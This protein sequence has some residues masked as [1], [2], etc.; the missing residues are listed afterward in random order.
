M[1]R[2]ELSFFDQRRGISTISER[3]GGQICCPPLRVRDGV[4]CVPRLV[5]WAVSVMMVVV[6]VVVECGHL[7][8]LRCAW[9][10]SSSFVL[11]CPVLSY[12][13][14][15]L[16][17]RVSRCEMSRPYP[18]LVKSRRPPVQ[19]SVLCFVVDRMAN[20][21][22]KVVDG[23]VGRRCTGGAKS[24]GQRV[25][26]RTRSVSAASSRQSCNQEA[27]KTRS[28]EAETVCSL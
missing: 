20:T 2:P 16:G 9:T 13:P 7:C 19:E 24:R 11:S 4:C 6:V 23:S 17:T 1:V 8:G 22:S 28:R 10:G 27:R 18:V 12:D 26:T 15:L 14:V 3:R 25:E 21:T 5:R